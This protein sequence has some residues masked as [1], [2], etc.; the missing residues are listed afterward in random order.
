MEL[1]ESTKA[2]ILSPETGMDTTDDSAAAAAAAAAA[3]SEG[4]S[5]TNDR[6][7]FAVEVLN[8]ILARLQIASM[9]GS[10]GGGGNPTTLRR[11]ALD[12]TITLLRTEAV[13]NASGT[14]G[15][16]VSAVTSFTHD[17]DDNDA[18]MTDSAAV[19]AG[20]AVGSGTLKCL[21][22]ALCSA[23]SETEKVE[24]LSIVGAPTVAD[25]ALTAAE[26][27][28]AAAMK[29]G[30]G[31]EGVDQALAL[32]TVVVETLKE[33]CCS[34]PTAE[35]SSSISSSMLRSAM[36]S[37]SS[38]RVSLA[39]AAA[40]VGFAVSSFRKAS[41]GG[42]AY[43]SGALQRAALSKLAELATDGVVDSQ[44]F[45]RLF[46]S[47][48]CYGGSNGLIGSKGPIG[49]ELE[50]RIM[51]PKLRDLGNAH[52]GARRTIALAAARRLNSVDPGG[53]FAVDLAVLVSQLMKSD[54]DGGDGGGGGGGGGDDSPAKILWGLLFRRRFARANPKVRV[55]EHSSLGWSFAWRVF[56]VCRR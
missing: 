52:P 34:S 31:G 43:P 22:N 56:A 15:G 54:A 28:A 38:P 3:T 9:G 32:A 35:G 55:R 24:V 17:D 45:R 1:W 11:I 36:W 20:A 29:A 27:A 49:M 41:P 2:F 10:T 14:A 12:L 48:S 4:V 51:L 40:L 33:L 26:A 25:A 18:T 5:N 46:F 53:S 19:N 30:E 16:D 7:S 21:V 42:N 44:P 37:G 39:A 50:A 13:A 47:G 6:A 8:M 23:E